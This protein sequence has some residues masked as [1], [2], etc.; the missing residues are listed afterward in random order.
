MQHRP[1]FLRHLFII[2]AMASL[3]FGQSPTPAYQP[4]PRSDGNSQ[5]AHEQL[6]EKTRRGKIDVYF[7]GDSI[8]RRWGATDYPD[9]LANWKQNFFGWNAANFGWGGDTIPN[10]LWRLENGELN[11][12]HP[13]IIVLLAG[14]NNVGREPGDEPKGPHIRQ[15][16]QPPLDP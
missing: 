8:T 13:K 7:V 3:V 4:L 9:F 14:P 12:V 10:I 6:I 11:D 1:F 16:I 2:A 5:L 15:G